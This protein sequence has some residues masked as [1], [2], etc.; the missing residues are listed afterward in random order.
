MKF[1]GETFKDISNRS[2]ITSV[3]YYVID[4]KLRMKKKLDVFLS[5]QLDYP[6]PDLV[7]VA[8]ELRLRF[9]DPDKLII[10]ILKYV[11]A[12]VRYMTDRDNFGKVEKWAGAYDAWKTKR[13]DCDDANCLI[14][15][16]ARLA[17]ISDLNIWSA[18]G[19][20]SIGGHYWIIYFS[21]KMAKWYTV[22]ATFYTSLKEISSPKVRYNRVP[23]TL[24]RHKYVNIWYLFNEQA[25]LTQR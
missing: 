1:L 24:S 6:H 14:Y 16:L 25:T 4:S 22:D 7:E 15:V 20:A 2:W 17:G 3:F 13:G 8:S 9:N 10:G 23:F 21:P 11:K 19:D 18:I 12:R 5:E